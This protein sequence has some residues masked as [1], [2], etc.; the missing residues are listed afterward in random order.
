MKEFKQDRR[1]DRR[2]S[3]RFSD[4]SRKSFK[5]R[6]SSKFRERG[7][8][9]FERDSESSFEKQMHT[10]T[11]DKCGERCQVPFRPTGDKPVYCRDCFRKSDNQDSKSSSSSSRNDLSEINRKLDKIMRF[12]EIN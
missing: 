4:D 9:R 12:L 3:G 1:S 8:S 7:H 10:V 11:C 2:S 5:R 6:D